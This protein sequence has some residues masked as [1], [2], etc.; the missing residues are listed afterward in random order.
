MRP[1]RIALLFLFTL[2]LHAQSI[3]TKAVDA[4]ML[5]TLKDWKIPGAAIAIV[6]DDRIVYVQGYGTKDAGGSDKVTAD[7]L[8][9]IASTSKAFTSTALAILASEGKLSFDD[10][11]REHLDYF[12]L[13]DD[14]ADANVTL[15]DIVSH[16]T[17]VSRHDE[18]WDNSPFSREEVV[19]R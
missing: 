19:R 12:H 14:C 16:R 18:L 2:T 7:T 1:L 10:P 8:F 4:L 9:Q 6:K 11:V 5:R 15:R 3:D 17:G 13:S